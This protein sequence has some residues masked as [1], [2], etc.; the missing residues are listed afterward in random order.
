MAKLDK[1][2]TMNND[3]DFLF[4]QITPGEINAAIAGRVRTVRRRRGISQEKLSELSGVSLGSLKRF[5]RSGEISLLS[6]T[7]LAIA[8]G[9]QDDMQ[10]LFANVP[11]ES[12]EEVKNAENN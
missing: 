12:I 9:L 10:Q 1:I 8:L 6:L 3:F 2:L 11:F 5:E 4:N 7:K